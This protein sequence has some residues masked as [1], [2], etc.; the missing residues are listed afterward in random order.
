MDRWLTRAAAAQHD[1]HR[2]VA[3]LRDLLPDYASSNSTYAPRP[4]GPNGE[5]RLVVVPRASRDAAG[6]S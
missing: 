2:A 5:P 3:L 6:A 4:T 1:K